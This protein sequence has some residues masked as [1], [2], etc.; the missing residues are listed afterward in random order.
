VTIALPLN[1]ASGIFERA[2]SSPQFTA[3]SSRPGK[4]TRN[5]LIGKLNS[6]R[7]RDHA[8]AHHH[9]QNLDDDSANISATEQ[10]QLSCESASCCGR[11]ATMA[12]DFALS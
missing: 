11:H 10:I 2:I 1:E 7:R 3:T 5:R 9:A 4:D 6:Q 8:V 12:H